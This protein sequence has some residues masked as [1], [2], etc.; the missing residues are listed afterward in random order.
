MLTTP[1]IFFLKFANRHI[2]SSLASKFFYLTNSLTSKSLVIALCQSGGETI[3]II[4]AIEINK[5]KE[6]KQKH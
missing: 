6:K 2:N 4:S 1:L 5:I 3:G